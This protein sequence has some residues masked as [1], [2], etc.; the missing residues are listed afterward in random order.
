MGSTT[1]LKNVKPASENDAQKI[2][3]LNVQA[4]DVDTEIA[5]MLSL[6]VAGS[7]S[8]TLT[9]A[10]AINNVFKFTGVLTGNKTVVLPVSLGCA[11]RFTVWNATT[12]AFTLTVK[13]DTGGSVGPTITQTKIVDCFHDGTDVKK[14]GTEV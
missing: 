7:G 1:N 2:A 3:T 9:R 4:D 8:V 10:Q 5:G 13:T 11:R 12:G 6:S 14:S